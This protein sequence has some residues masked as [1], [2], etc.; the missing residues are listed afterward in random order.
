MKLFRVYLLLIAALF[1]HVLYRKWGLYSYDEYYY[2]I[3]KDYEDNQKRIATERAL[4][5]ALEAY[6]RNNN[7][8]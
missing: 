6:R 1:C 7:G 3:R 8:R 4:R 2:R 5:E